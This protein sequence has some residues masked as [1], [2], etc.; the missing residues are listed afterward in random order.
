MFKKM[1][2]DF[3]GKIKDFSNEAFSK[4]PEIISRAMKDTAK[5]TAMLYDVLLEF[6]TRLD[7]EKKK[8]N[9]LDFSDVRR[10]TLKLLLNEDKTPTST[11]KKYADEFSHIY[12]DEYQDVDEVQDL[13][14]SAISKPTNRFMVGDI[15]QSIYSFRGAEPKVFASYRSSFPDHNDAEAYKSDCQTIFMSNNFRCDK[16]VIDFTNLVCSYI[17]SAC[18]ESIGYKKSDDLEFSKIGQPENYE[19]PRVDVTIITLPRK[20]RSKE[21]EKIDTNDPL[22]DTDVFDPK[23]CEARFIASEINRLIKHEKKSDGTP[24]NPGDIAV[25]SRAKSMNAYI[26]DALHEYGILTS[27]SDSDKYFENPDVLMT[28]CI[29]NAIDNPQRDIFLTGALRSSIF[30]F[31]M[32]DLIQV[33]KNCD[34]SHSLYDAV[35]VYAQDASPLAEKCA[36]F[37]ETLSE[38]RD[39]AAALPVDKFLQFLFNTDIFVASGLLTPSENGTCGN[40]LRLYE[41]ARNFETGSFKG[42][43]QFIEFI[44]TLIEEGKKLE[45]PPMSISPDKVSLMSIHQS[46]GLEFPVC[47]V[48][49]T[50]SKFNQSDQ[51]ESLLFDYP[52]GVAMKIADS[53][54][55]ARINTPM[56]DAIRQN[57]NIKQTEEEMRVLYVAMTR[58][59]ERL[60]LTAATKRDKDSLLSAAELRSKLFGRHVIMECTS[61]L[62]WILMAALSSPDDPS[63]NLS[64]I[65]G[66]TIADSDKTESE[67]MTSDGNEINE[68]LYELLKEKFAFKYPY[69]DFARVPAKISVSKL[70]P[71]VLDEFDTS[72]KLIPYDKSA[73][74]PDFF[75]TDKPSRASAAE[76]GIATHLF[77]QFCNFERTKE[78]G[79]DEELSL[80]TEQ[81]FIPPNTASL[82]FKDELEAFFKSTL[83]DEILNA[84]Q[85]IREQRF[86]LLMPTSEFTKDKEFAER[87]KDEHLAVQG[88]IDLIVITQDGRICVYDYKT[89]R[90]TK[91]ELASD[92]FAGEKLNKHHALQLSY[93]ARAV[94]M[95]FERPCDELFIY[96]THAAK[97]F[98]VKRVPLSVL[99]SIDTL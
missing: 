9:F 46:K 94:E 38:W 17:F 27:E 79:V 13:I 36:S 85:V 92:K 64:F 50:A 88:V 45:S 62:D 47:F 2:D 16:N 41:Y 81:R 63:Y 4:A 18:T 25:L 8:R 69:S 54:G 86:N 95:I 40:V 60:Y 7:D 5:H 72:A 75:K 22:E 77:L 37:I 56:R 15:K 57:V 53:G 26:A 35:C 66:G 87:L 65:D 6:N 1:R 71:D 97:L 52:L 28:L 67:N 23:E 73:A 78:N 24:I 84:K 10:Y 32:D 70:S 14:F 61:Y 96:S 55:F 51:K 48:C 39:N 44:N 89:D 93:Y 91:E 58:A 80:L 42:L 43:Y 49:G 20:D 30:G 19:S 59:R 74:V 34:P 82:I 76:R 99:D 68:E 11:A 29:L 21:A 83:I 33:R 98:E 12:I 90:L 31:T 3:N